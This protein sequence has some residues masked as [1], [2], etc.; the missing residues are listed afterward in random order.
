MS[1]RYQA[2]TIGNALAALIGIITCHAYSVCLQIL[3]NETQ[4]C[5]CGL[6][7]VSLT[8]MLCVR[9]EAYSASYCERCV[10]FFWLMA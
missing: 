4:R 1:L 10:R 6:A 2:T 3:E 5:P 7:H 8:L 9:E